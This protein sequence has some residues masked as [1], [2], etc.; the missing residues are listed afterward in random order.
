METGPILRAM[1]RNK[2]GALLIA[3]Q[4]AVTQTVMGNPWVVI[5]DRLEQD[6]RPRGRN[7]EQV[8]HVQSRGETA[9]RTGSAADEDGIALL[10]R[11]D[12]SPHGSV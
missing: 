8:F 5:P 7:E 12:R 9:Q 11:H 2:I 6:Q 3:L 10:P 4:I 1:M